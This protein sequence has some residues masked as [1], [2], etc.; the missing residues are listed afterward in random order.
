MNEYTTLFDWVEQQKRAMLAP[1][2]EIHFFVLSP[3]HY[4]AWLSDGY[5]EDWDYSI[6]SYTSFEEISSNDAPWPICNWYNYYVLSGVPHWA[7]E[8]TVVLCNLDRRE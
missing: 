5:D 8:W 7:N 6:D 1:D 2:T 4:E 3:E